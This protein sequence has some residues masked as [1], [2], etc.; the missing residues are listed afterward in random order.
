MGFMGA[1]LRVALVFAGAATT[2]GAAAP[3]ASDARVPGMLTSS[4]PRPPRTRGALG[5]APSLGGPFLRAPLADSAVCSSRSPQRASLSLR[6][7]RRGAKEELAD[8]AGFEDAVEEVEEVLTS[9]LQAASNALHGV[10]RKLTE[11]PDENEVRKRLEAFAKMHG[12]A[13]AAP[14]TEENL[15]HEAPI[16]YPPIP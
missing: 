11:D 7:G 3:F 8:L 4:S 1:S 10:W 9:T 6:M 12:G 5:F 16:P 14:F 15:G 2:A 13:V